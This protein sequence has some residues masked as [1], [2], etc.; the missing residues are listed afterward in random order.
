MF[1]SLRS[2]YLSGKTEPEKFRRSCLEG[3]SREIF[4]REDDILHALYLDLGKPAS[5]AYVSEVGFV[6]N[7]IGYALKNI[8]TWMKKTICKNTAYVQACQ[9]FYFT[10]AK[11]GCT[12]TGTMELSFSAS[13]SAFNR[14]HRCRKLRGSQG[15]TAYS[16]NSK[17]N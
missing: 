15:I 13:F 17:D 3:L 6:L 7:E 5:E 12:Y 9:K 11:R 10:I 2:F 16:I 4:K 14:G 8:H 1:E